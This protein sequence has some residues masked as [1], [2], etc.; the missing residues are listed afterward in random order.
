MKISRNWLQT[1][2]DSQLPGHEDLSNLF[3]FHSCEVEGVEHAS[4]LDHVLDIK[5]LPDRAHYLL[6][7]QGAAEEI[8]AI[9]GFKIKPDFL[10]HNRAAV[11]EKV[12]AEGHIDSPDIKVTDEA[13][14][15]RYM[16]RFVKNIIVKE[17]PSWLK[18]WLE[19]V[20]ARS[21]NNIVD[22]T[23][24]IMLDSGQPLHAF[25]ADKVRG[26]IVVRRAEAGEKIIT[27]DQKE[28]ILSIEDNVIADDEGPIAIAGIKGGSRAAV[29]EHTKNIIIESAR[30]HPTQVRKTSQ[31]I[32]IR[33]ESSKRF[34]NEISE[35][36]ASIG[37]HCVS[38]LILSM[39]PEAQ[40]GPVGDAYPNMLP[41]RKI[42]ISPSR[43]TSLLGMNLSHQ[44]MMETLLKL[45]L[46]TS[47]FSDE[48]WHITIPPERLDI[49]SEPDI[50]DEIGRIIGYDKLENLQVQPLLGEIEIS[51]SISE[52][53]KIKKCLIDQGYGEAYLY[54][55]AEK[56][57]I[58]IEHPLASDKSYTRNNIIDGLLSV[59]EMN[60]RNADILSSEDVLLEAIRMF[61]I[62][63]TFKDGKEIW[64]LA[65]V[66]R[67]L[68][69][70]KGI[71]AK[72]KLEETIEHIRER[73]GLD[74]LSNAS[75]LEKDLTAFVEISLDSFFSSKEGKN[76]DALDLIQSQ[77]LKTISEFVQFKEFSIYP[78]ISRDAALFVEENVNEEAVKDLIISNASSTLLQKVTLFDVFVKKSEDPNIAAK[79]SL[80]YRLVFQSFEKTLTDEGVL[81]IMN[82]VYEALKVKGYEIR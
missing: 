15:S 34:E 40:F 29:D 80:A 63:K 70:Q 61:E 3:T 37:M 8:S 16:S 11:A 64:S 67:L 60:A 65:I 25:D 5:V 82:R 21:I 38:A 59:A 28:V 1:Y 43:I 68:K 55:F 42:S 51:S 57:D 17:S 74:I 44:I 71:S 9:T 46:Q 66:H 24:Y 58:Q 76:N 2:F 31:R 45:N 77:P 62:G 56:G 30:F 26:L 20:G 10:R 27:L 35:T 52:G 41:I 7:H 19:A 36:L 23:N 14:C 73:T 50:A 47:I 48:E 13:F 81:E 72:Q 69:K 53:I 22:A 49:V 6:S 18:H 54:T 79:K 4:D 33:N 39:V 75:I 78:F 12:V 32:G